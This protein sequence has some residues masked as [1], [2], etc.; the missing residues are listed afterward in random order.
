MIFFIIYV[1]FIGVALQF[2]KTYRIKN[3]VINILEQQQY[4]G[5]ANDS[6]LTKLDS[7][8]DGVPYPANKYNAIASVEC[9]KR[10]GDEVTVY[11]GVCIVPMPQGSDKTEYF[12]VEVYFAAEF[13]FLDINLAIPAS[14][15]TKII[16]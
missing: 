16:Y 14:G 4:R 15:E 7:Y 10:Y 13:P 3:N 1:T 12:R 9:P 5:D 6:A 11:H 8:L 2:A